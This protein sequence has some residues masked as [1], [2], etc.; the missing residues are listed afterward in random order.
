[1]S[2]VNKDEIRIELYPQISHINPSKYKKKYKKEGFNQEKYFKNKFDSQYNRFNEYDSRK[3]SKD[4]STLSTSNEDIIEK[5]LY[6]KNPSPNR[7]N[8]NTNIYKGNASDFKIKYKTEL[9]KYY[10]IE[11]HCKYGNNCAYA[12]GID[13]LRSKVTNSM[14]YRTRKCIQFFESGY[15]PYGSRCQ[16]QHQLKTNIINNPYDA[17]MSY[18]KI[19]KT[20]SKMENVENIKKLMEKPRLQIFKEI[21]DN[22]SIEQ[23]ES[24]LLDDI[25]SLKNDN[26]SLFERK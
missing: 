26:I 16:F 4:S 5:D 2:K 1:M 17:K 18:T 9:C 22:S 7:H 10:E 6:E 25:K 3:Y 23:K 19:M 24:T 13:N 21:V 15:C 20:I 8:N 11:G 14:F 12:H